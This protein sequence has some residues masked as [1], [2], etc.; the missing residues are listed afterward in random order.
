MKTLEVEKDAL[1]NDCVRE[2][3]TEVGEPLRF[4][5]DELACKKC[6]VLI[7]SQN[8]LTLFNMTVKG[9]IHNCDVNEVL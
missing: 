7:H 6:A 4:A 9:I 1:I 2:C 3:G 8:L 5:S